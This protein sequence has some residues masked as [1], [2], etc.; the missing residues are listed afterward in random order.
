MTEWAEDANVEWAVNA[1]IKPPSLKEI[2]SMPVEDSGVSFTT[3]IG[4]NDYNHEHDL[5]FMDVR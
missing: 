2:L 1:D 4:R 5:R 3:Q